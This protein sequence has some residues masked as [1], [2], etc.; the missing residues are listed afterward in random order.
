MSDKERTSN[1]IIRF[2]KFINLAVITWIF[3]HVWSISY[4]KAIASAFYIKGELFV[5]ALFAFLYLN[6]IRA[7]DGFQVPISRIS[8]LVY[9]QALAILISNIAMYVVTFLLNK[10]FPKVLPFVGIMVLQLLFALIW[11][12][13]IKRWYYR[14]DRKSV[15]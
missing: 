15:V 9:S 4:S 12:V 13:L 1:S 10:G 5:A 6:L 2:F 11:C 3:F 8:E 7:Y 14:T